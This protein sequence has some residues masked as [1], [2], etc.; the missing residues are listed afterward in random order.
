MAFIPTKPVNNN[1]VMV[2]GSTWYQKFIPLNP[3]GTVYDCTVLDTGNLN[4]LTDPIS[5][6]E[7]GDQTLTVAAADATGITFSLTAAQVGAIQAMLGTNRGAQNV[8]AG[9]GTDTLNVAYGNIALTIT[10]LPSA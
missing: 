6:V 8:T 1:I 10:G 5:Q 9:D 2:Q 3:D 4:I 7:L